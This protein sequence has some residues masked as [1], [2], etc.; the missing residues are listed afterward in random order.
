MPAIFQAQIAKKINNALSIRVIVICS[1]HKLLWRNSYKGVG[2][3]STLPESILH[4]IIRL[5]LLFSW[6][7][8]KFWPWSGQPSLVWVWKIYPKQSQIFQFIPF[9]KKIS[10]ARVK[11]YLVKRQVGLLF[12]AS[13]KYARVGSGPI[14]TYEVDLIGGFKKKQDIAIGQWS[15]VTF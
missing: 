11:K 6:C 2:C 5:L 8:E 4:R 12:S 9:G 3:A 7:R 15:F 1:G 13:Q 14:S 10:S